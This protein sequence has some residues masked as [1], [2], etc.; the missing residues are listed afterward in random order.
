MRNHSVLDEVREGRERISRECDH[1]ISRLMAYLRHYSD[2]CAEQLR[3]YSETHGGE[4]AG[5]GALPAQERNS[6]EQAGLSDQHADKQ[7]T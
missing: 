2:K 4:G 6:T 7:P 5:G 3:R 1:D